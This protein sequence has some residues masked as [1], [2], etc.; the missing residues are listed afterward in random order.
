MEHD[1]RHLSTEF[2]MDAWLDATDILIPGSHSANDVPATRPFVH[3]VGPHGEAY[4]GQWPEG[5]VEPQIEAYIRVLSTMHAANESAIPAPISGPDGYIGLVKDRLYSAQTWLPG[6]PL[7]RFGGYR[8]PDGDAIQLPLPESAHANTVI[9]QV[10]SIVATAHASSESVDQANLPTATLQQTMNRVRQ[11]WKDTRPVL[12]D[13]AADERDIRRWLRSGNRIVPTASDLIR[14]EQAELRDTSVVLHNDLWPENILIAGREDE[15]NV[16]GIVGW[17]HMSI[18]SPVLDIAQ[19][20]VQMQGWSAALTEAIIESYSAN[21]HLRP[22]QRRL[23]VAVAG[24][25][26]VEIVGNMLTWS[27]LDQRMFDHEATPVLRSGMKTMLDSLE[28]VTA[29]LAPDI[30]RTQRGYAQKRTDNG[31]SRPRPQGARPQRKK[32]GT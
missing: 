10:A 17:R 22:D 4:L 32:P 1:Y 27:Y 8:T 7:G 24:L 2:D 5:T 16:T 21:R 12:G 19:M 18:G 25:L 30:D 28:R 20:S 9:A 31:Q 13:K 23:V 11:Y 3:M 26:L 15:R 14:N 6:R 29:I